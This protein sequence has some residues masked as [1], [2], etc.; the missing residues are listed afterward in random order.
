[1]H[2][3]NFRAGSSNVLDGMFSKEVKKDFPTSKAGREDVANFQAYADNDIN[4]TEDFI[5]AGKAV[6]TV[7]NGKG[8]HYTYKV[9]RKEDGDKVIYFV[10]L[11]TGP[12]NTSNYTYIGLLNTF[13]KALTLKLT[14]ASKMT[15]NSKPVQVFNW[16]LSVI[17]KVKTLPEGYSIQHEGRC[18]R[19]SRVLTDPE[20]IRTGLGPIC[21]DASY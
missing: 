20:S 6:F 21:R 9:T 12:D 3:H 8:T 4:V 10:G 5:K 14:R 17:Q 13:A 11:L 16:A 2:L 15:W 19:C 1:M 7:D 18:A